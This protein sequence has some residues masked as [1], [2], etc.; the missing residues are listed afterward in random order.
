MDTPWILSLQ[1]LATSNLPVC[2]GSPCL[3]I[4]YNTTVTGLL[5]FLIKTFCVYE[6]FVCLYVCI[7]CTCL[8]AHMCVHCVHAWMHVCA[9]TMYTPGCMHVCALYTRLDACMCTVYTPGGEK[10]VSIPM[11]IKLW[12]DVSCHVGAGDLCKSS[13]CP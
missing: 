5:Y 9:C 13:E 2:M 6:Y 7:L 4:P 12:I 3:G 10:R 1:P 11:E 8:G